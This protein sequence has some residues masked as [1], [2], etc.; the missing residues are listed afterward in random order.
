VIG[1][2]PR[3]IV[4]SIEPL[5]AAVPREQLFHPLAPRRSH[6]CAQRWI[7]QQRRNRRAE[8]VGVAAIDQK[9]GL[10][11]DYDLRERA[12]ASGHDRQACRHRL[13]HRNAEGL[14]P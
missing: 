4:E 11:V 13:D 5:D 12:A 8:P 1:S 14:V 9:S 3:E 6:A 7:R 2:G 10:P